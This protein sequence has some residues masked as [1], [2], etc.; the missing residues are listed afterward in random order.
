M[1][2]K[3]A[4]SG[5]LGLGLSF[6]VFADPG[7][8]LPEGPKSG[9]DEALPGSDEESM[10]EEQID[11]LGTLEGII[12][13]MKDAESTLAKLKDHQAVTEQGEVVKSEEELLKSADLQKKAIEQ[14]SRIFE[15]GK[16]EQEAAVQG[17][18]KLIKAAKE[19]D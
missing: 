12:G 18:E 6:P 15:G 17:L 11:V 7:E 16:N 19:G 9:G 4:L 2:W 13:K 10:E 14:M 3:L 5:V 1:R 8:E